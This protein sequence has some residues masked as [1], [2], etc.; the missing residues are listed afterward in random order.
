MARLSPMRITKTIG[1][2]SPQQEGQADDGQGQHRGVEAGQAFQA[3][4][5][6]AEGIP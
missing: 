2:N 5:G 3:P 6:A 4:E 1:R